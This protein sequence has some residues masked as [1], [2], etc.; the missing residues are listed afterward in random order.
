MKK[1]SED[2]TIK[3]LIN[4]FLPKIWLI[5]IVSIVLAA[6]LGGYS[7]IFEE[8]TYTSKG[9]FMMSKINMSDNDAQ[10]GL[11]ANEFQAMQMMIANAQE[12][13]NT[14]KFAGK[15]LDRL[16]EQ[17]SPIDVSVNQLKN[18]MS[19]SLSGEETTCY[20]FSV[21]STDKSLVQPVAKCA[22]ELLIEE[23]GRMTKYAI[24]IEEIDA[25]LVPGVPNGKNTVRNAI[26]GFAGG[27]LL[28]MLAVFIV[29]RFDVIIRS[30]EKIEE[31]LA[32]PILGVIPRLEVEK[33][34]ITE[35]G[36]EK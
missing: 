26:I 3:G 31:T 13:I 12:I 29:S 19:V 28:S 34:Q 27:V 9:K 6:V 20:Y 22:G 32:L 14:N 17:G 4:I 2:I 5:A 24:T 7:V 1:Q 33:Q 15:V 23:Y 35:G 36:E 11:N 16:E 30:R 21:T 10:T 25:P 8:D 18:M